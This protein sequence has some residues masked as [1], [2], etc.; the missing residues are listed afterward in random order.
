MYKIYE[1]RHKGLTRYRVVKITKHN[2]STSEIAICTCAKRK[3]AQ[4][5]IDN[6]DKFEV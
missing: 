2:I 6:I 3:V 4:W 5:I 1:V